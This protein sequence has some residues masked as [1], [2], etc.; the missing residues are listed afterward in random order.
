[1]K[2]KEKRTGKELGKTR[3][4]RPWDG[5]LLPF[6]EGGGIPICEE[7]A[8]RGGGSRS[9]ESD[10]SRAERTL[11]REGEV[12]RRPRGSMMRCYVSVIEERGMPFLL[13]VNLRREELSHLGGG[14]DDSAA[15]APLSRLTR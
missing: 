15:A 10:R 9:T 13:K 14:A 3:I 11:R 8:T 12:A 6:E 7:R 2:R 1:M 5:A 4:Y